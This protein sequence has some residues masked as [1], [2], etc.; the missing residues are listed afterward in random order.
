[1]FRTWT[2]FEK[3]AQENSEMAYCRTVAVLA[4]EFFNNHFITGRLGK[5]LIYRKSRCF[6]RRNREKSD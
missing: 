4:K 2:R 6:W 1:M 3:E 5:V